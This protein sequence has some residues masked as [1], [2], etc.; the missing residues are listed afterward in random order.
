MEIYQKMNE[1]LMKIGCF[2]PVCG[3]AL[4][5]HSY[6]ITIT[7]SGEQNGVTVGNFKGCP[8]GH[9]T[10]EGI[11]CARWDSSERDLPDLVFHVTSELFDEEE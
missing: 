3:K 6:K 10:F 11:E 2:C 5:N 8:D 9:V 7:N 1:I 4:E